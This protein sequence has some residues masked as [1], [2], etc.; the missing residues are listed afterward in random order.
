MQSVSFTVLCILVCLIALRPTAQQLHR[1][2]QRQSVPKQICLAGFLRLPRRQRDAW[3]S[4]IR[5]AITELCRASARIAN[6]VCPELDSAL[7]EHLDDVH[8]ITSPKATHATRIPD[9]SA[10]AHKST[11]SRDCS[12]EKLSSLDV[13]PGRP[14]GIRFRDEVNLQTVYR[15]SKGSRGHAGQTSCDKVSC[16]LVIPFSNVPV[17]MNVSMDKSRVDLIK[18]AGL[19]VRG[20]VA[21]RHEYTVSRSRAQVCSLN[22]RCATDHEQE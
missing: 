5:S 14:L 7:W 20:T 10:C 8:S 3:R 13:L 18:T 16:L 17:S 22:E 9:T 15:R 1:Y 6:L 19:E 2:R 4:S 11:T 21:S 12:S